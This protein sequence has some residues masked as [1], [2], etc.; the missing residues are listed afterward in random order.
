MKKFTGLRKTLMIG[1]LAMATLVSTE[2]ATTTVKSDLTL[3]Q[4]V[5][6]AISSCDVKEVYGSYLE[7]YE[8]QNRY[9]KDLFSANY[10]ER[11]LGE[12]RYQFNMKHINDKVAADTT[13]V[14]LN[15]VLTNKQISLL[16]EKIELQE[17]QLKQMELKKEKG[18]A[19]ILDYKNAEDQLT[20]TK[21]S[22]VQ[23]EKSLDDLSIR[24]KNLTH[25]EIKNYQLEEEFNLEEPAIEGTPE[26]YFDKSLQDYYA[27]Q[28]EVIEINELRQGTIFDTD[29]ASYLQLEA[30][31]VQSKYDLK[32][33]KENCQ[34]QLMAYYNALARYKVAVESYNAQLNTEK[35]KIKAQEVKYEKGLISKIEYESA[36]V[37]LHSL[38]YNRVESICSYMK[39]KVKVERP[40]SVVIQG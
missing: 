18:L 3:E 27:L 1:I 23:A 21:A 38:E 29:Y 11:N 16:K 35:E 40:N 14:Y 19:S 30:K 25:M 4:A 33:L 7:A 24:F 8:E 2:A 10:R 9:S 5:S 26:A 28:Q 22:L 20:S 15:V 34:T 39:N 32:T 36:L 13:E 17:K 12:K 37:G 6:R 31:T